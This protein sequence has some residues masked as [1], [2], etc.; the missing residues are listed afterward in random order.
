MRRFVLTTLVIGLVGTLTDLL[1]LGHIEEPRQLI[2]LAVIGAALVL[3]AW[4]GLRPRPW[5]LQALR[6]VMVLSVASGLVGIGLHYTASAEFQREVD[7]SIGGRALALK[8]LRAKAPPALA[9]GAMVY[10][11]LLGLAFAFRH[12]VMTDEV[13]ATRPEDR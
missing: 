2:P 11:G 3:L 6:L 4:H 9:P 7:P 12:P 8:A 10:L 1:L 13:D 5:V